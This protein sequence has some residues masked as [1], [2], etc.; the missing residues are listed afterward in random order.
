MTQFS[1]KNPPPIFPSPKILKDK[2]QRKKHN[3]W[4]GRTSRQ[5]FLQSTNTFMELT[6]GK[7][8]KATMNGQ[9]Q[10]SDLVRDLCATVLRITG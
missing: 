9:L 6:A 7:S 1:H 8:I 5:T 2:V 3:N 4:K 10:A